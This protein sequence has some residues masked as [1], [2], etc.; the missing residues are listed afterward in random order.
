MAGRQGLLGVLCDAMLN[1]EAHDDPI[2]T[3]RSHGKALRPS[4]LNQ[5]RSHGKKRKVHGFPE[6]QP[7]PTAPPAPPAPPSP[8]SLRIHLRRT[9]LGWAVVK[10]P[11]AGRPDPEPSDLNPVDEGT[12]QLKESDLW[13]RGCL[14]STRHYIEC[15]KTNFA[16]WQVYLMR[17]GNCGT[18]NATPTL[19]P[20]LKS[21]N[22]PDLSVIQ[23]LADTYTVNDMNLNEFRSRRMAASVRKW[24]ALPVTCQWQLCFR[25]VSGC[26]RNIFKAT[27]TGPV[28]KA[29]LVGDSEYE[30]L[31]PT[32]IVVPPG[33]P[34]RVETC[35][36]AKLP[37]LGRL[38][39][40]PTLC[41]TTVKY[42]QNRDGS[43]AVD[44]IN[45]GQVALRI[46]KDSAFMIARVVLYSRTSDWPKAVYAHRREVDIR[47]VSI[48]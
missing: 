8:S 18:F 30:F 12:Y 1:L 21:D 4:T 32:T 19:I 9:S 44:I 36:M 25:K 34:T 45:T 11:E 15:R 2:D 35:R 48:T 16:C 3:E 40:E 7:R 37:I 43:F 24:G 46:A 29:Q 28:A 20:A 26:Q 6:Q 14:H 41:H 17:C 31:A 5:R 10:H 22:F 42:V 33:S 23:G 38:S 13:C 27:N 39:L 47:D